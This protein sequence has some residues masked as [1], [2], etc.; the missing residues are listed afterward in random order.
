MNLKTVVQQYADA[1]LADR[2]RLDHLLRVQFH[3][4]KAAYQR[5]LDADKE[6]GP[7]TP[8]SSQNS[9]PSS[10]QAFL[11]ETV[12]LACASAPPSGTANVTAGSPLVGFSFFD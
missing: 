6:N 11:E 7:D 1:P 10:S 9:Q 4:S 2:N 5:I 3:L 12:D 8:S